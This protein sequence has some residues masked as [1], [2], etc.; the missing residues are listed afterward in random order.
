[1][2]T[3]LIYIIVLFFT[4]LSCDPILDESYKTKDFYPE[5]VSPTVPVKDPMEALFKAKLQYTGFVYPEISGYTEDSI[6]PDSVA[7]K[8]IFKYKEDEN[9]VNFEYGIFISKNGNFGLTDPNVIHI[10]F[11]GI[12]K[13]GLEKRYT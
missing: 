8:P 5:V 6:S 11:K 4:V 9:P 1:M 3:K 12:F 7:K 13:N 10:S 2:K